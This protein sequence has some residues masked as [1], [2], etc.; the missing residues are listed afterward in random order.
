MSSVV[1]CSAKG[2]HVSS[3]LGEYDS[4][5]LRLGFSNCCK[6]LEFE[7]NEVTTRIEYS[8]QQLN[9]DMITV[10]FYDIG[11]S[12]D[13]QVEQLTAFSLTGEIFS[14]FIKTTLRAN[15]KS[16]QR[17]LPNDL[18]NALS[19]EPKVAMERFHQWIKMIH[20]MNT[21]GNSDL[22][23]VVLTAH[24]GSC[25][26][27]IYLLRTML[28]CGVVPPDFR[29]ADSLALFMLIKGSDEDAGIALLVAKYATWMQYDPN[30]ADNDARALRTLIMTVFPETK[31]ACY[32][33][34]ARNFWRGLD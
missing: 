30:N 9:V 25:H 31:A 13:G 17:K 4:M 22:R 34:A 7:S 5:M 16:A 24:F 33:S 27:H 23:N 29:L 6:H 3:G 21:R 10:V 20:S 2:C 14:S 19:E 26:Y 28:G 12:M 8:T 18:Y 1:K 15:K 32:A 11:L